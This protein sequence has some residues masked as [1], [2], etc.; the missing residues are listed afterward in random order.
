M[1]PVTGQD[2]CEV[3]EVFVGVAQRVVAIS[4]QDVYRAYGIL[5]GTE[6]GETVSVPLREESPLRS[7]LFPYR[8]RVSPDNRLYNYDKICAERTFMSDPG[9]PGTVLRFPMVYGPGDY[10]HRLFQ[11]LKR[12]DDGRPA[13]LLSEGLAEWR[14]T[15][16][17]VENVADAVVRAVTT[18]S[19]AGR[20]YNVGEEDASSE[21]EWVRAIGDV[22]G[23]DGRIIVVQE[24]RLPDRFASGMHTSQHLVADSSRIR[25]ELGYDEQ[26]SRNEALRRT[27]SWERANPPDPYDAAQF[28][29][30][31]EDA[32]LKKLERND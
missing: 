2:A 18:E 30:D 3:M 17:Y 5:I 13:I 14:C 19:A 4:S 31:A 7:K 1:I 29:Y 22:A 26:V 11:Y 23:W 25:K 28:D 15:K 6:S 20:I 10:Q 16:G 27:I 32:L 12:M 9:L 24:D 21:Y 8:D